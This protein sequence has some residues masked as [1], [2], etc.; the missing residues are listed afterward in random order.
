MATPWKH[1]RRKGQNKRDNMKHRKTLVKE[2]NWAKV[3]DW[4]FGPDKKRPSWAF[5]PYLTEEHMLSP[6]LRARLAH[7]C[8]DGGVR[9]PGAVYVYKRKKG[10]M[11]I[12]ASCSNPACAGEKLTDEIRF[13]YT[14]V[15]HM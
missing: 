3:G 9:A 11:T 5:L 12:Q 13:L 10:G 1:R 6:K 4:Y 14:L 7:A 2:E 8:K 15:D